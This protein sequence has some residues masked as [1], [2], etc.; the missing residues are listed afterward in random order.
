MV[1]IY[2]VRRAV[3]LSVVGLIIIIIGQCVDNI[4]NGIELLGFTSLYW[5][6]FFWLT[7][8]VGK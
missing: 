2:R 5:G 1:N 6:V 7:R 3:L 4:I 8:K